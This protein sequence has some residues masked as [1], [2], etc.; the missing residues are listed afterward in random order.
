MIINTNTTDDNTTITTQDNEFE[1][2]GDAQ[3]PLVSAVTA[4]LEEHSENGQLLLTNLVTSYS[5]TLGPVLIE[6]SN[7][8]ATICTKADKDYNA[9]TDRVSHLSNT[10]SVLQD[11]LDTL[12]ERLD[13][14]KE[15][16][17]N[18]A[19]ERQRKHSFAF[20][21]R[22]AS[23]RGLAP[24]VVTGVTCSPSGEVISYDLRG[25]GVI[26]IGRSGSQ[27]VHYR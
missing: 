17:R 11:T 15:Q 9:L 18:N 5:S 10:I 16:A 19:R 2:S 1:G 25:G 22:H 3:H 23:T 4:L 6:L 20:A 8:L 26:N 21:R 24:E 27:G 7:A 13:K 14:E 12:T